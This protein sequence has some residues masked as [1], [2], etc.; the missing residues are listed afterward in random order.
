MLISDGGGRILRR[1]KRDGANWQAMVSVR[2]DAHCGVRSYHSSDM[3][4]FP[5]DGNATTDRFQVSIRDAWLVVACIGLALALGQALRLHEHR[6]CSGPHLAPT[7]QSAA[8]ASVVHAGFLLVV[9]RVG[10]WTAMMGGICAA[11]AWSLACLVDP[12]LLATPNA[13]IA[14]YAPVLGAGLSFLLIRYKC[15]TSMGS[16]AAAALASGFILT[17]VLH[18]WFGSLT[19]H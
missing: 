4:L 10:R 8:L 13:T 14:S 19:F 6:Y 11:L 2:L 12:R 3:R 7:A 16:S 17:V 9:T 15:G 5:E 18:Q 1:S